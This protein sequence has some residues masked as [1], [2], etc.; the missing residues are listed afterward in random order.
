MNIKAKDGTIHLNKTAKSMQEIAGIDIY[1]DKKTGQIKDMTVLLDELQGKWSTLS[2]EERLALSNAI[3][4]KQN[5]AVFQSLMGNYETF[6][7]IQSEFNEGLHFGSTAKENEQYVDSIAGKLNQLKETWTSIVTT[8]AKSDFIKGA[9][10]GLISL[11]EVIEKIVSSDIGSFAVG[12]AGL[13]KVFSS[14]G[15]TFGIGK[16]LGNLL[17]IGD[18]AKDIGD[19]VAS[20]KGLDKTF[21]KT[22]KSIKDVVKSLGLFS[23]VGATATTLITTG[24]IG[25]IAA[26]VA[27]DKYQQKARQKRMEESRE[28]IKNLENEIKTEKQ[29]LDSVRDVAK[30]YDQLRSKSSLTAEEQ[31]RYLELTRQIAQTFPELVSGYDE[32]GDPILKLNGS[33][34]TYIG[35][36]DRAIEKQEKLLKTEENKLAKE[37][38]DRREE[39]D[40][41]EWTTRDDNFQ[42]KI[43]TPVSPYDPNGKFDAELYQKR[44]EERKE[45]EQEWYDDRLEYVEEKEKAISEVRE[46]YRN[47]LQED[48]YYKN[49]SQKDKE[50]M[51]ET[52]DG[53]DLYSMGEDNAEEFTRGLAKQREEIVSTTEEMDEHKDKIN[54]IE[55]SY[56]NGEITLDE[57]SK[58]MANIYKEAGKMD[59]ESLFGW[60]AEVEEYAEIT[61]DLEGALRQ[62]KEISKALE[63]VT[64]IDADLWEQ[65][66]TPNFEPVE[67]AKER[68]NE[69]LNLYNTG[70]EHLGKGGL[71]D[72]LEREYQSMNTFTEKS[73][74]EFA[75][76]GYL[77]KEF[78][79]EYTFDAPTPLKN[80]MAA[81]LKDDGKVDEEEYE[82]YLRIQTDI[83][84]K[85]EITPET[86]EL[87][88][89]YLPDEIEDEVIASLKVETDVQ[90]EKEIDDFLKKRDEL[91]SDIEFEIR[92]HSDSVG[93]A[94]AL[95]DAIMKLPEE[96]RLNAVSNYGQ[97]KD[98]LYQAGVAI[99]EIPPEVLVNISANMNDKQLNMFTEVLKQVDGKTVTTFLQ[100]EGALEALAKCESVEQMLDLINGKKTV[101][102]IEVENGNAEEKTEATKQSLQSVEGSYQADLMV[103]TDTGNM[104]YVVGQVYEID[105][106]QYIC[107]IN[108][109]TN[110]KE[111]TP[112]KEKVESLPE[113][114]TVTVSV[115]QAKANVLDSI[116]NWI[117][118]KANTSVSV[119]VKVTG[120]DAINQ[121]K[122]AIDS[123]SNKNIS[124]NVTGNALTQVNQIKSALTSVQTKSISINAVG[125]ALSQINS[126]KSA[127]ASLQTKTVQINGNP[128]NALSSISS[129][130][131]QLTSIPDKTVKILADSSNAMSK[132]ANVKSGL[133]SI[134]KTTTVTIKA[135]ASQAISAINSV[136][137]ALAGVKNKTVSVK[138]NKTVTESRVSQSSNGRVLNSSTPMFTNSSLAS[139]PVSI[140]ASPLSS[141]PVTISESSSSLS[142]VPVTA[143]ANSFGGTLDASKILP[144][145]DFDISH[146][147][148][149][150]EALERL[151]NQLDF[152]DEKAEATFGQEKVDLLQQQIPLLREQQKIQEQIAKNER[153]QNNELIYWLSN[154]GFTFDNLGNITNYNDKL[155]EMEQN[156][157]SLKKKYDALNDVSGDK[158][159]ESAIKDAN[160]AYESANDTLSKTKKYLEEYFATNNKEITEAS[161]KW[162]EYENSIR[163]AEKAIRDLANAKFQ[164]EI[165][166]IGEEIDFL[167]SKIENLNDDEKVQYLD[168]QNKLYREQQ[169]LMHELAEQMRSQLATLD[170]NSDEYIELQKEIIN[171]STEWWE[172]ESAIKATNEQLEEIRRNQAIEPLE[173]SLQEVEYLLDRH[174]DRLDLIDAQYENATGAERVEGLIKKEQILNEQ[175]AA[176]EE[177]YK[178]I[179][180]LAAGLQNDLWQFGFKLDEN[181]LISNYDEVLNSLIGT[182]KYEQAKK[183]ADEYMKVVRGDLIDIQI[184][185]LETQNA[186]EDLAK[187]I[188][189][190]LEEAR[191]ERL[192][193]FKNSLQDVRYELDRVNDRLDLLNEANAR[194]QGQTKIDYLYN[195]LDLLNEKVQTSQKEF[196]ALYNLIAAT[197]NDLWQYG[198]RLD[199]NSLIS[200]YDDVLNDLVGTDEYENAKKVADEYMELM[201]DDYIEN[202]LE[203]LETQNAIKDLQDEIE[204]AEREL[205]LFAST[206]RLKQLNSEFDELAS[207][208]D[209][210]DSK[211]EYAFGSDK[212]NLMRKEIELLNNQLDLQSKK[213]EAMNEQAAIYTADLS[214]YGFKFD[215]DG[216]ISNYEEIME[217]FKNDEQVEKI[218]EL[219]DE[220]MDLQGEINDLS[221]EYANLENSVKDV[222]SEMLDTTQ[223][224]EQEITELIE[225]E[226]EIICL[227]C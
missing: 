114:K 223:E 82:L 32:N 200:N 116:A 61:G 73:A 79:L 71:A 40:L 42:Y 158:K 8:F 163:D 224:I 139:I 55:E 207:K 84:N 21:G 192:E 24:L 188:Q 37:H 226:Y 159:N 206:N 78:V 181:S 145:L 41:K 196:D 179:Y 91:N 30:E 144:S 58:G 89:E 72:K 96:K 164:N 54:E 215:A 222:Y 205:A 220:Y 113:K 137:S 202:K 161:K 102:E 218:K 77:S 111:L 172:L 174:S 178:R 194:S 86:E 95:Y 39:L 201:R 14:L 135:N 130:R 10:D 154:K 153:A 217:L 214:K 92:M 31:E 156:V 97:I 56:A 140:S 93:E 175:L 13:A 68:L 146:I 98:E 46:K 216:S 70:A 169:S 53:L 160:K 186:I 16:T 155:L 34:E 143:R 221:S 47:D 123:M 19:V 100:Q 1:A 185:A 166:L 152:L 142:S 197:Q 132:I 115:E 5:A 225:K 108:V 191:Q 209:I 88:R 51:E 26:T 109:D 126:I 112:L 48:A 170:K 219:C 11:S 43:S 20:G 67:R 167:D 162:W 66:L 131:S 28:N 7:Q 134:P 110:E 27:Y 62:I 212:L 2:E 63:E 171:L 44:L 213:L 203:I 193:P 23:S 25:V 173:N 184:E 129:V 33:L 45:N 124:V 90:A 59:N 57:Y 127:L 141:T 190:A 117:N 227:L 120:Q 104:D 106:Q 151:G 3:A 9:L 118:S 168:Q 69:F 65:V 76:K 83:I 85:G 103:A 128:S 12:F 105:G 18:T 60:L 38:E 133:A 150:E 87:L 177:A 199:E 94:E 35:N 6:K 36:L 50:E 148:N 204:K 147:K 99:N 195:Q 138:V 15:K 75:E 125:N 157:E 121:V 122:S 208:L 101:A 17:D 74:K 183:Y 165:D 198:F 64:G 211:L 136:K 182:D 52:L 107:T 210:I 119:S 80:A 176:Q 187:E 49:A 189:E 180:N 22:T 4:G 149:L 29:K 81:F